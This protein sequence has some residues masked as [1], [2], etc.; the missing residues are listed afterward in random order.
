MLEAVQRLA[1]RLM[2][3]VYSAYSSPDKTIQSSEGVQQ[4]DPLVPIFSAELFIVSVPN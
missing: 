3:F 2:S 4:G 1:P